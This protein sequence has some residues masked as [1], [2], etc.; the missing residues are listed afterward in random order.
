MA[1]RS[2][3]STDR[4]SRETDN[5][6]PH[7]HSPYSSSSSSDLDEFQSAMSFAKKDGVFITLTIASFKEGRKKI[8]DLY[9]HNFSKSKHVKSLF[10]NLLLSDDKNDPKRNLQ[11]SLSELEEDE[12]EEKEREK[13]KEKNRKSTIR[14]SSS[15]SP[16]AK[17]SSSPVKKQEVKQEQEEQ[18]YFIT[19]NNEEKEEGEQGGRGGEDEEDGAMIA[20]KKVIRRDGDDLLPTT[21]EEEKEEKEV[22]DQ[23]SVDSEELGDDWNALTKV[24][25]GGGGQQ[26]PVFPFTTVVGVSPW[27]Q[28]SKKWGDPRHYI[29][30][31]NFSS[32]WRMEIFW[33]DSDGVLITRN[34]LFQGATHFELFSSN[35]VW[36]VV[37]T[38]LRSFSL[39]RGGGGGGNNNGPV[40]GTASAFSLLVNKSHE[41]ATSPAENNSLGQTATGAADESSSPVI[42]LL[43]PSKATCKEE[44]KCLSLLWSPGSSLSLSNLLYS[45]VVSRPNSEGERRGKEERIRPAIHVQLFETVVSKESTSNNNTNNNTSNH[46]SNSNIL[47]GESSSRER[48][49]DPNNNN[50]NNSSNNDNNN[51]D[52]GK[53]TRKPLRSSR[54]LSKIHK[55]TKQ[56]P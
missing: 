26:Q 25:G 36:A 9:L 7:N 13:E 18:K 12:E 16:T 39:L 30:F 23:Q 1:R 4:E 27:L 21:E 3:R 17:S 50:S 33:I 37:A 38:P 35:H 47:F 53:L 15:S 54:L 44:S 48:G 41:S 55:Q 6:P 28:S 51:N 29:Q 20:G 14:R 52:L 45:K 22:D 8:D 56:Q 11:R 31:S 32:A 10:S 40:G 19:N 43:R 2:S 5:Q 24:D 34:D 49:R 42:L 46:N